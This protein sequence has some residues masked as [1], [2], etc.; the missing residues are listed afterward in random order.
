[1]SLV[2]HF[3]GLRVLE[4][5]IA[6]GVSA[7]KWPPVLDQINGYNSSLIILYCPDEMML[8]KLIGRRRQAVHVLVCSWMLLLHQPA[9]PL[10][11]R[12]PSTRRFTDATATAS[13]HI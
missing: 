7:L 9:L 13:G 10:A 11:G 5:L 1:M 4:R 2:V 3:H 6:T 12:T 8:V